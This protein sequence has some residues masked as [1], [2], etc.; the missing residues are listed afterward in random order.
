MVDYNIGH[1]ECVACAL[2]GNTV[3]EDV[4]AERIQLTGSSLPGFM[5]SNFS[6]NCSSVADYAVY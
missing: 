6:Q 5:F 2:Q 1:K 3:V 4:L